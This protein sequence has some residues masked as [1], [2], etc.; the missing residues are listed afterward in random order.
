MNSEAAYEYFAKN[1]VNA[2]ANNFY[3]LECSRHLGLGD[4]G[5]IRAGLAPYNTADEIDR[6]LTCVDELAHR[7]Y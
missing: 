1:N 5:A 7:A 2:P 6:L 3:A 4:E